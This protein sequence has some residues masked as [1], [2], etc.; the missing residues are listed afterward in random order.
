M[1]GG[2]RVKPEVLKVSG[3]AL[4][5][6]KMVPPLHSHKIAEPVMGQLVGDSVQTGAILLVG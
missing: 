1:L 2:H 4:L 6:P 5:E 3:E